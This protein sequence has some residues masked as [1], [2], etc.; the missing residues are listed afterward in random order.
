MYIYTEILYV[1]RNLITRNNDRDIWQ[2]VIPP[3]HK[4]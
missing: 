3:S 1:Y 4:I 2:N